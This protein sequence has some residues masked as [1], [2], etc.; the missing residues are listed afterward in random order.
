M[1]TSGRGRLFAA[2]RRGVGMAQQGPDADG[3]REGEPAESLGREW[4]RPDRHLSRARG[5]VSPRA[6]TQSPFF[7]LLVSPSLSGLA[8]GSS[9]G[10]GSAFH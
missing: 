1:L 5:M 3:P 7:G 4:P 2:P 6:Y 10:H 8:V 9:A